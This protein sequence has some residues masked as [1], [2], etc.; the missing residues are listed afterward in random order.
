MVIINCVCVTIGSQLLDNLFLKMY[1]WC[2]HSFCYNGVFGL[3][4][5]RRGRLSPTPILALVG[6]S[7]HPPLTLLHF[8]LLC[9][10]SFWT[11]LVGT[12]SPPYHLYMLMCFTLNIFGTLFGHYQLAPPTHTFQ[13][14]SFSSYILCNMQTHIFFQNLLHIAHRL[15]FSHFLWLHIKCSAPKNQ[16]GSQKPSLIQV[17]VLINPG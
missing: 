10:E 1:S 14:P 6:T 8:A 13:C 2:R 15:D 4:D 7:W 5:L 16:I 12:P 17:C 11:L 9:F 3:T